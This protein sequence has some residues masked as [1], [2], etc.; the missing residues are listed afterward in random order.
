MPKLGALGDGDLRCEDRPRD[1]A[2]F[3]ALGEW[4]GLRLAT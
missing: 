2:R 4:E 1:A 3:L